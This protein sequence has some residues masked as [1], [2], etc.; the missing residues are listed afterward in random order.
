MTPDASSIV[1]LG[2]GVIDITSAKVIAA[3]TTA[4]GRESIVAGI[5]RKQ[6]EQAVYQGSPVRYRYN[7]SDGQQYARGGAISTADTIAS[8]ASS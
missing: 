3:E 4:K 7:L 8:G 1:L 5:A 6:E 2:P